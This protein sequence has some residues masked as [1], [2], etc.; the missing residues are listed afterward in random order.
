MT[1]VWLVIGSHEDSEDG[2]VNNVC[3]TKEIADLWQKRL[4]DNED[5][6]VEWTVEEWIIDEP[7]PEPDYLNRLMNK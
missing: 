4:K 2:W 5:P 6:S 3:S 7:I 1:T